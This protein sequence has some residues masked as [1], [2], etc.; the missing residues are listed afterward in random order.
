MPRE[1]TRYS[2]RALF[3]LTAAEMDQ[4]PTDEFF[5]N[6]Y[7]YSQIEEKKRIESKHGSS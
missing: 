3:G 5:T 1:M 6:L 4:E 2:Y 7:I